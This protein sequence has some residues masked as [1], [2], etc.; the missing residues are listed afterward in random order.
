MSWGFVNDANRKNGRS[1]FATNADDASGTA[2]SRAPHSTSRPQSS[3]RHPGTCH[4]PARAQAYPDPLSRRPMVRSGS[5]GRSGAWFQVTPVSCGMSPVTK[6][7]RC[8]AHSG[9][10]Q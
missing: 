9:C 8:G 10:A 1:A 5:S 7:E 6:L 4:L 3:G 2:S